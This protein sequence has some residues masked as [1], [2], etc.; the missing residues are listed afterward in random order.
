MEYIESMAIKEFL[1]QT[2]KSL[3]PL[4]SFWLSISMS[5]RSWSEMFRGNRAE[6][7]ISG[8]EKSV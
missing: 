7:K 4:M 5:Q 6:S 1:R 3:I 8:V 2:K